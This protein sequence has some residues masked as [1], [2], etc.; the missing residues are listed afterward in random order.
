MARPRF[1]PAELEPTGKFY[2]PVTSFG[3]IQMPPQPVPNRPITPR[4]NI[5][6]LAQGKKP[7]W[8]PIGG[9]G[10]ADV[11]GFRPRINGDNVANHQIFD[12]GPP[13]DY[14]GY[15]D[16]IESTWFG[17][18]W[19]TTDIGGAMMR[20]GAPK[21]PDITR[22]EEYVTFPDLDAADWEECRVQNIEY[23][24]TDK[25][26]QLGIQC[27]IWERLMAL[28][29]VAEACIALVD[30][31]L[32]P[33]THR[34]FDAYTDFLIDYIKRVK[35]VCN[36][37]SVVIHEDWA[38]Q[39]GPFMA[40]DTA[41]EML[42]PYVKRITDYLHGEGMLYEIHMCGATEALIPL[43]FEAGV[44]MWSAIQPL[45]Y[46][47]EALVKKY[48]DERFI[49]G[50]TAPPVTPDFTEDEMR[51]AAKAFVEEYKDCKILVSFFSM[52]ADFP[53][54]HPGFQDAVY[55]YSRI[56]FQDED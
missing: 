56:A 12:G 44:D 50:I 54:Y 14:S 53:G 25:L 24:G 3:G 46:D 55:E 23:L 27:G 4:E 49:F 10:S 43:Y 51:A 8:F 40:P 11:L 29:D 19:E 13:F 6:L 42:V 36:I 39:R 28:M 34:F 15:G 37:N 45:L 16:I 22:W 20:P 9:F 7:Y 32:K 48:K 1:S 26:N 38:H 21:L 41:R 30:E 33:H 18:D 52:A 47:T 35:A 17:L 31:D 2:P 5:M